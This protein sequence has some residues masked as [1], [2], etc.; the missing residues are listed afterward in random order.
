MKNK[1]VV[2][3]LWTILHFLHL[4]NFSVSYEDSYIN[5]ADLQPLVFEYK[6]FAEIERQCSRILASGSKVEL[7]DAK[8]ENIKNELSFYNGDWEQE[9]N[10]LA[11]LMPF[12]VTDLPLGSESDA[13]KLI[14]FEVKDVN[15]LDDVQNGVGLGGIMSIGITRSKSFSS[16]LRTMFSMNPGLSVLTIVFEG[17][18][19]EIKENGGERALCLLG[20]T[21]FPSRRSNAYWNT[22]PENQCPIL[23]EDDQLLLDLKYPKTS[24]LSAGAIHGEIRSVHERESFKFFDKVLISSQLGWWSEYQFSQFNPSQSSSC[25]TYAHQ[26]ELMEDGASNLNGSDFCRIFQEMSNEIFSILPGHDTNYDLTDIGKLGPFVLGNE[27]VSV[28][29]SNRNVKLVIQNV[30]CKEE[31]SHGKAGN[32]KVSAVL[33]VVPAQLDRFTASSRTGSS[34]MTLMAEGM[35]DSSTGMLCMLGSV[36]K[37]M[38]AK[39][40][41]YF[42]RSFSIRQRSIVFGSIEGLFSPLFFNVIHRPFHLE[43]R[44]GWYVESYL[45]YNYSK[46]DQADK[47]RKQSQ[48]FSIARILQQSVLRYPAI[49]EAGG[50]FSLSQTYDL[51]DELYISAKVSS[52]AGE[53]IKLEMISIGP[54]LARYDYAYKIQHEGVLADT[55]T[56]LND[57][58]LLNVSLCLTISEIP[59]VSV[60]RS[61]RSDTS[62]F[63]E[64]LYD[65]R[66][67]LMYLIGCRMAD[68]GVHVERSLDCLIEMKV[69]YPAKKLRWLRDSKID[70]SITSQRNADDPLYFSPMKIESKTITSYIYQQNE[71]EGDVAFRNI[72]EGVLRVV[73]LAMEITIIWSQ[74]L[75]MDRIAVRIVSSVCLNMFAMQILSYTILLSIGKEILLPP[76]ECLSYYHAYRLLAYQPVLKSLA[77]AAKFLALTALLL[78]AMLFCKVSKFRKRLNDDEPSTTPRTLGDWRVLLSLLKR[79]A[80]VYLVLLTIIITLSLY[81]EGKHV[82][83]IACF[84]LVDLLIELSFSLHDFPLLPQIFENWQWKNQVKSLRKIYYIGLPLL[85]IMLK[86]YDRVRAPISHPYVAREPEKLNL[87][88][89]E[90]LL[91]ISQVIII[92]VQQNF[93]YF[94]LIDYLKVIQMLNPWKLKQLLFK[95]RHQ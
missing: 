86:I 13:L 85:Q 61:H 59:I 46:I 58:G 53:S 39:V 55:K 10:G 25:N 72:F 26:K 65:P 33:R 57:N 70:I 73:V 42:P 15:P 83:E 8:I 49:Q 88:D 29:K 17:V 21:T 78:N 80:F 48:S 18:Y 27:G 2:Y 44:Y 9:N 20:N 74:K 31:T 94:W 56:L 89:F 76:K 69:Q 7:T 16:D 6:R 12:D 87:F 71:H 67:G 4:F 68:A 30:K 54:F 64:G 32:A 51:A 77:Y 41:M 60:S 79:L 66:S 22:S 95:P 75:Y 91:L 14:N 84:V 19:V 34:S 93:S 43:S 52:V 92:H 50:F 45:S 5:Y 36:P 23:M 40:S 63:V 11:S 3:G 82:M 81:E 24:S 47:F 37:G 62:L 1:F 28:D 38:D 90:I 35:W